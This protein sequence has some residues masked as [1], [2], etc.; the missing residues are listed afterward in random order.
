MSRPSSEQF[1]RLFELSEII[2]QSA[3]WERLSESDI[4]GVDIPD[5]GPTV[6]LNAMGSMREHR[7]IA[8]YL[9]PGAL[10]DL[11]ELQNS[12]EPINTFQ[13]L[14]IPHC[15]VSFEARRDLEVADLAVLRKTK[16]KFERDGHPSFR[17]TIAGFAPT[18]INADHARIL[19]IALEQLVRILRRSEV[20]GELALFREDAFLVRS[21]QN[22]TDWTESWRAIERP[23]PEY[24]ETDLPAD[25]K[26][27][28]RK[29]PKRRAVTVQMDVFPVPML[30]DDENVHG[31]IPRSLVAID[32]TG[33]ELLESVLFTRARST[34]ANF[35]LLV[36]NFVEVIEKLGYRPGKILYFSDELENLASELGDDLEIAFAEGR[37]YTP[38][39]VLRE[40]VARAGFGG[41]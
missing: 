40:A 9:G 15:N 7:A 10:F 41:N 31:A 5:G 20:E 33:D 2:W 13:L 30:I 22:G 27:R 14:E 8:V 4:L 16:R 11:I 28:I 17:H 25:V 21:S 6:F 39:S 3:P 32:K 19:I 18:P 24:F 34:K 35:E 29:L 38:F 1:E 37:D 36:S 26:Q 12:T 23:P